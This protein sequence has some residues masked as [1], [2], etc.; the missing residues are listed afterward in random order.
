MANEANGVLTLA[1]I[2]TTQQV[3][4]CDNNYRSPLITGLSDQTRF[5]R[6]DCGGLG[7]GLRILACAAKQ[8]ANSCEQCGKKV[9]RRNVHK[10]NPSVTFFLCDV[11][12]EFTVSRGRDCSARLRQF[13]PRDAGG[14][15]SLIG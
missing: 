7:A 1:S 3:H 5:L 13:G 9:T 15:V 11:H 12:R 6:E 14:N 2:T 8:S 4:H 10:N